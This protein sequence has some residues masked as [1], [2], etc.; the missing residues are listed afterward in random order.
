MLDCANGA[1]YRAAPLAFERL[2]A[3]VETVA[4]EPDGR[5]INDGCGSTHIESSASASAT[6]TP[7]SAS[8]STAT[9]TACWRW[10]A[11]GA[12]TTATS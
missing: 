12:S 8:P 11:T 5:N 6:R 1:A 2:G 10:T 4:D 7:T 9:P 3:T